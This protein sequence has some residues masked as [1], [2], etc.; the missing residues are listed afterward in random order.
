MI[1]FTRLLVGLL[2]LFVGLIGI[3]LPIMPG[4]PFIFVGLQVLGLG[5]L[6]PVPL[7]NIVRTTTER[8]IGKQ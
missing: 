6:V 8:F 2:L 4:L 1:S 3:V 5:V 7:R